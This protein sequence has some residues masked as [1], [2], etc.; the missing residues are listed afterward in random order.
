[1]EFQPFQDKAVETA[2]A[3]FAEAERSNLLTLRE[4]IFDVAANIPEVGPLQECLKW[5]QPSYLTATSKSG[6]T[7]RLGTPKT[8]G[9]ALFV[10]CQTKLIS[11]FRATF[12]DA[13]IYEGNRAIVFKGNEIKND[14]LLN[15]FIGQALT[16]HVK[17]KKALTK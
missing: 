13:F 1:M 7:I 4:M 2:F 10:H 11:D 8:G 6:T 14:D 9:V 5:G 16:Y 15:L 12:P 3:T 17:E